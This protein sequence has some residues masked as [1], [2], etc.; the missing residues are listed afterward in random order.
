MEFEEEPKLKLFHFPLIEDL[1]IELQ[2]CLFSYCHFYFHQRTADLKKDGNEAFS[3]GKFKAAISTYSRA[4]HM[5]Y[6]ID[7]TPVV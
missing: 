1:V 3:N 2:R 6:C 7:Q 5:R 4:L